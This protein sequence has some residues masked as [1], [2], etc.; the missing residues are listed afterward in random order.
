[1]SHDVINIPPDLTKQKVKTKIVEK[2]STIYKTHLPV[3]IDSL[4]LLTISFWY[5]FFTG[6]AILFGRNI[7]KSWLK[8]ATYLSK[9][10]IAKKIQEMAEAQEKKPTKFRVVDLDTRKTL[11]DDKSMPPVTSP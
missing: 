7:P 8:I 2:L 4:I 1:M 6:L 3:F 5:F 9:G 10:K 11:Y